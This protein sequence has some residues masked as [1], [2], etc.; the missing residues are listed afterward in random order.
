MASDDSH[1]EE[2][3]PEYELEVQDEHGETVVTARLDLPAAEAFRLFCDPIHLSEWLFVVG[4][5]V[6]GRR[7]ARGRPL[8]IDFMG[9]LDRCSISYA[10]GY[11]YDD[12]T[13]EVRWDQT[14]GSPT[15]IC[16]H[17]RFVPRDDGSCTLRYVLT[18]QLPGHLPPWSDELYRSR[19]AETVVL[20]FCEWLR[21]RPRP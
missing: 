10:L 1:L 19:P 17:A 9:S 6:V 3:F 4:T 15:R 18:A 16:G 7:D 13:L 11:S 8:E 21:S 14:R 2:A 20:D 12:A 5:V